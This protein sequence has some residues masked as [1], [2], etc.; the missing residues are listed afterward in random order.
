MWGF[1]LQFTDVGVVIGRVELFHPD[2]TLIARPQGKVSKCSPQC[3]QDQAW[4]FVIQ[5][6]SVKRY[7]LMNKGIVSA[8][9]NLL[10]T[11]KT[12][13]STIKPCVDLLCSSDA[14]P[15][16]WVCC[17]LICATSGWLV[18]EIMM[19]MLLPRVAVDEPRGRGSDLSGGKSWKFRDCFIS[20]AAL[21]TSSCFR[22]RRCL[23][24]MRFKSS[25]WS[26]CCW[27][28]LA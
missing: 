8:C 22:R 28:K 26:S 27:V 11:P 23:A 24:G 17:W 25:H 9:W 16:V 19:M 12:P 21:E 20:T 4:A 10:I 6:S 2:P 18:G 5:L 15:D 13:H 14:S 7:S 3:N 1:W